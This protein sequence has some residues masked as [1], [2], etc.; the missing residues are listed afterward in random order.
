MSAGPERR[1]GSAVLAQP[2][3]S[4]VSA[5]VE[6]SQANVNLK[7]REVFVAGRSPVQTFQSSWENLGGDADWMMLFPLYLSA[8]EG[9]LTH[10][11]A[12]F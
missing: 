7:V 1:E 10:R 2:A 11:C 12:V 9:P 8:V 4:V 6:A 3:F 5:A